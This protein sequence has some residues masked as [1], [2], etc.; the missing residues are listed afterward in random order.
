MRPEPPDARDLLALI[1]FCAEAMWMAA[2]GYGGATRDERDQVVTLWRKR[3]SGWTDAEGQRCAL[4]VEQLDGCARR[5]Q[6]SGAAKAARHLHRL[7]LQ[8][9]MRGYGIQWPPEGLALGFPPRRPGESSPR[10]LADYGTVD[11][12][13]GYFKIVEIRMPSLGGKGGPPDPS[14]DATQDPK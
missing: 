1:S 3:F 14:A 2:A 8:K 7:A 13:P 10:W 11:V 12:P 9:L 4:W 5:S 6:F